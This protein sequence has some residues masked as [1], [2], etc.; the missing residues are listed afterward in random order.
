MLGGTVTALWTALA[1][2]VLVAYRPGGPLDLVVGA[3]AFL[4]AIVASLAVAWPPVA[5]SWRRA[6][7]LAWIGIVTALLVAPLIGLVVTQLV[8]NASSKTLL[9]SPEVAYAA[10]VAAALSSSFAALGVV[11]ARDERGDPAAEG[12]ALSQRPSLFAALALAGT[13]TALMT[14]LFGATALFNELAIRE[15]PAPFSRYGPTDASVAPPL[16]DAPIAT[17]PGAT[18]EVS[19]SALIDRETVGGATL[20]GERAGSD[21][22]WTGSADGPSGPVV[23]GYTRVGDDAWLLSRG[24]WVPTEPDPF[25]MRGSDQLT[26][27]GPVAVTAV[28][29]REPPVAEDLGLELIEGAHAR[30]CRTAIDGPTALATFVPLRWLAGGGA[31][32]ARAPLEAWRGTME[33]WVF[34]DGELGQASLTLDGYPGDAWQSSGL[35]GE[36]QVRMTALDRTAPHHVA[37]PA[38]AAPSSP[39]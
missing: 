28:G 5:R 12:T 13:L 26:V 17:G 2:V 36:L 9:P 24:R 15:V 33:W 14:V 27:D 11:A 39:T 35:Q 6:V 38:V 29:L 34:G 21:E 22:I 18:L 16:C 37:P 31:V 4:P 3:L 32:L 10:F 19:A 23:T 25:G 1:I 20:V 8:T 30:H 7:T